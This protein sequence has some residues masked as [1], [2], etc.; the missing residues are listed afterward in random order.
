MSKKKYE[1]E[2][3]VE[4]GVQGGMDTFDDAKNAL[5]GKTDNGQSHSKSVSAENQDAE[6]I[7]TNK[8]LLD[9]IGRLYFNLSA[10]ITDGLVHVMKCLEKRET[11]IIMDPPEQGEDL[12]ETKQRKR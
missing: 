1:S 7:V 8:I 12:F 9:A 6:M 4:T 2:A 11:E 3:K 5:E 10:L